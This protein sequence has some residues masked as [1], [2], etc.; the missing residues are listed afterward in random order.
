VTLETPS[1]LDT[2]SAWCFTVTHVEKSGWIYVPTSNVVT[3]QCEGATPSG[4][5]GGWVGP[6]ALALRVSPNPSR[7]ESVIELRLPAMQ[8]VRLTIFDLS[9]RQVREVFSAPLTAGEHV[10]R[11]DGL[12]ASGRVAAA[13]VYFAT[14]TAGDKRIST[15]VMRMR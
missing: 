14:V 6:R 8:K 11:W 2:T 13:G 15:R 5:V 1:T 10:F 12:D 7:G 4:S 3:V 9:G